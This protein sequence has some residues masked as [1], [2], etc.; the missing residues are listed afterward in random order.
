MIGKILWVEQG[1]ALEV[2]K[3]T[4]VLG[5]KKA[6][7]LMENEDIKRLLAMLEKKG[8]VNGTVA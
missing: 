4:L 6:W 8:L 3:A 7:Y 2:N 1:N 5:F